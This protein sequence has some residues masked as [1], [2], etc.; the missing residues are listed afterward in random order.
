MNTNDIQRTGQVIDTEYIF[1]KLH[2]DE[3][4]PTLKQRIKRLFWKKVK[5]ENINTDARVVT[6]NDFQRTD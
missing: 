2:E 5:V 3:Y 4:K 6:N 1:F